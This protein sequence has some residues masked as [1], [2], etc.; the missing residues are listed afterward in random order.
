MSC[1]VDATVTVTV[2]EQAAPVVGTTTDFSICEGS[3]VTAALLNASI[4]GNDPGTWNSTTGGA[5]VYTYTVPATLPCTVDAAVTVTVSE[6]EAP[7]AGTSSETIEFCSTDS[8]SVDQTTLFANL[9]DADSGGAWTDSSGNSV[10]FPITTAG[11]YTYTVA[12]NAPCTIAD[13]AEVTITIISCAPP[14]IALELEAVF[15]DENGDNIAQAEETI[16]YTYSVT[17]TGGVPLTDIEIEDSLGT[18][19]LCALTSLAPANRNLRCSS[20]Y[21]SKPFDIIN[22]SVTNVATVTALDLN[23]N[24]ITDISDDPNNPTN[25]DFDNDGNPD[26]STII[27][28]PDIP[29]EI[30]N[31]VSSNDDGLN[32]FFLLSGIEYFP[33]NNVKIYNRWGLLVFETDGYGGSTG[34]ENVFRGYSEGRTTINKDRLL[35][36]GTY[37]YLIKREHPATGEQLIDKG[38]LYVN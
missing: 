35:T 21:I 33:N 37:F 10:T 32:D 17:N 6:Q 5:G 38:F 24:V 19:V 14:S 3:S 22:G 28:F 16:T 8:I 15:N 31:V 7:I 9:T 26:D 23:G 34:R 11:T 25:M 4:T 30:F 18:N 1:T 12:S 36:T 27:I 20:S 29:F 2:S 13:T